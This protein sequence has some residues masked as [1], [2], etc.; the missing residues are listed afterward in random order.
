MEGLAMKTTTIMALIVAAAVVAYVVYRYRKT[1]P[2][3][4]SASGAASLA[5]SLSTPAGLNQAISGGGYTPDT[6]QSPSVSY[7]ATGGATATLPLTEVSS[8]NYTPPQGAAM[9]SIAGI[10]LSPQGY[11]NASSALQTPVNTGTA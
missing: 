11:G 9:T 6:T 5:D 3:S 7:P 8:G 4:T 10:T 2:A 1:A